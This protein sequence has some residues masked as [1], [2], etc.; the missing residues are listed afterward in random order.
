[1]TK[2]ILITIILLFIPLATS[3]NL[4]LDNGPE[5]TLL[6]INAKWNQYNNV[7]FDK[8]PNCK[9]QF[10]FLEDQPKEIQSTIQYVPHVVLLK[11]NRPIAQWSADLSFK[12]DVSTQEV[13][14]IINTH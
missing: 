2:Y 14:N 3:N 10:A 4:P 6:H 1:M 13:I 12:L 9:I 7:T 5:Y 8:I 11:Q